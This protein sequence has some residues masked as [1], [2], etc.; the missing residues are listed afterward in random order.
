MDFAAGCF[1]SYISKTQKEGFLKGV[2]T[3]P[4][5]SLKVSFKVSIN[6]PLS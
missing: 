1:K 5:G 3:V 2:I 6:L 4:E